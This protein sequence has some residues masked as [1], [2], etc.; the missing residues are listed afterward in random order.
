MNKSLT[1]IIV[2]VLVIVGAATFF[3][4]SNNNKSDK[5]TEQTEVVEETPQSSTS[6]DANS[7]EPSSNP[8]DQNEQTSSVA[9]ENFAF[10]PNALT[11]KKGTTV[12]WTNQDTAEHNV[13]SEDDG[14]PKGDLLSKGESFS[15]TFNKVGTFNYI[16]QPHPHMKG[17]VTV[18]D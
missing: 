1:A 18:T 7:P 10:S 3:V 9:I 16:C 17:T 8:T 5:A 6:I 14:G 13:F 15:F 11:V 2:I 4:V 12:T